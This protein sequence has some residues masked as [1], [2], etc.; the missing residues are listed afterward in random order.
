MAGIF[1]AVVG[2]SGVGIVRRAWLRAG[3]RFAPLPHA[4]G[5]SVR[6]WRLHLGGL[7]P[8]RARRGHRRGRGHG[9]AN[10]AQGSRAGHGPGTSRALGT[11]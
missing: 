5:G 6:A 7:G 3:R 4:A 1:F 9:P 10:R 2:A 8:A 11:A